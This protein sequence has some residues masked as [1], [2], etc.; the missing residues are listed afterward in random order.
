MKRPLLAALLAA[1]I[2]PTL[3][4][5]VAAVATGVTAGALAVI[6]RRTF[7]TQ[8][9]D[10]GIEWK[11]LGNLMNKYGDKV[12]VNQTSFNRKVLLTGEVPDEQTKSEIERLVRGI[13]GVQ[14]VWNELQVGPVRSYQNRSNDA[15]ITSKVKG[16]F[17]D[18]GKFRANLVKVVTEGGTV[19]LLGLVT[20]AEADAAIEITRTTAGVQKVVNVMEI[21]TPEK[22]KALDVP[23]PDS[24]KTQQP[25]PVQ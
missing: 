21:I 20:R 11:I 1:L 8:T 3:T 15:F 24:G 22:A 13:S 18:G 12:H 17:V 2:A 6:D 23:P 14:D 9:E 4:G 16:R 19:H 10:E 7:G 25:A 5:C